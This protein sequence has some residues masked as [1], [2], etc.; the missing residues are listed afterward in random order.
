MQAE[1]EEAAR[2]AAEEEEEARKSE[3]REK[4]KAAQRAKR[5]QLKKVRMGWTL[6]GGCAE[7]KANA[8]EESLRVDLIKKAAPNSKLMPVRTF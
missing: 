2:I 1:A 7:G 3:E 5:E 8:S 4:K 6:G